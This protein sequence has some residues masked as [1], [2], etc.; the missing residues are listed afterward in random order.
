MDILI[1]N[2]HTWQALTT[3]VKLMIHFLFFLQCE[4][5]F[6]QRLAS[7]KWH[8]GLRFISIPVKSVCAHT[9]ICYFPAIQCFSVLLDLLLTVLCT[10]TQSKMW[11]DIRGVHYLK[12]NAKT[13][14]LLIHFQTQRIQTYC[15]VFQ[16]LSVG[17]IT[18]T[19]GTG[20][21]RAAWDNSSP[22]EILLNLVMGQRQHK[23][24][25]RPPFLFH[26][27]PSKHCPAVQQQ[28]L[29]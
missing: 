24:Q 6:W 7:R 23:H 9:T 10:V 4:F 26:F 2:A 28:Y 18:V 21:I 15:L 12:H 13:I 8:V 17:R 5:H 20:S 22:S 25:L 11:F 1:L 29:G 19:W 27:N 3:E 14:L 16:S